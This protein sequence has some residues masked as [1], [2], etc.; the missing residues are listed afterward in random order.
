MKK[1]INLKNKCKVCSTLKYMDLG[2]PWWFSGGESDLQYS[3]HGLD[4]GTRT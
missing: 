4:W 2:L 3:G 1:L